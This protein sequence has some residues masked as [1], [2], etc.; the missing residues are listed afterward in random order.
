MRNDEN[1]VSKRIETLHDDLK[2]NGDKV[3][4]EF[5]GEISK[6]GAPM[7]EKI[8]GYDENYLVTLV[9]KE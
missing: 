3:L 1:I 6:S 8:E 9:W 4:K 5:W 7:V 2:I